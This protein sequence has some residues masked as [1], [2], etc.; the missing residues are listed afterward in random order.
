MARGCPIT[1]MV[2]EYRQDDDPHWVQGGWMG[3]DGWVEEGREGW[4]E[5]W[6]E[7]RVVIEWKER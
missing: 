7:G 2:L 1:H 5:E 3:V 4:Q 6:V